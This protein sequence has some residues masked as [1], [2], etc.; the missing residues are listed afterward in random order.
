MNILVRPILTEKTLR[1][2]SDQNR[3]TFQVTPNSTKPQIKHAVE[4]QFG[5]Q[6]ANV[7]TITIPGETRRRLRSR[8]TYRTPN[9]KKAIVQLN[10]GQ[11]IDLFQTKSSK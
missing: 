11:T 5:V 4:H 3:Y 10:S 7:R 9:T 6:V 1:L 8:N 2:V